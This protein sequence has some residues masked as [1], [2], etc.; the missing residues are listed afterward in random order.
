MPVF[1]STAMVPVVNVSRCY[2]NAKKSNGSPAILPAFLFGSRK[3]RREI[4]EENVLSSFPW[5][6]PKIFIKFM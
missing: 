6:N 5:I 4:N 1:Y 2:L 3:N